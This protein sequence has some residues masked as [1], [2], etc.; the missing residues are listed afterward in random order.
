MRWMIL[1]GLPATLGLIL[2]AE[3][4]MYTLFQ[5]DRFSAHDALMASRSL[6]AYAIGLPGF[7]A[8]KILAPG[9]SARQ[10]LATPAR[11]GVYAVLVNLALS[12]LLVLII[13]PEG[14][15]HA[16]L[17]LAVSLA[18]IYNAALLFGKLA[19]E[20]VYHAM[21][22]ARPFYGRV[23]LAN[24][25]MGAL[26]LRAAA[27]HPWPIWTTTERVLHL[28]LWIALGCAAYVLTLALTGLRPRHLLL[29]NGA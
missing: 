17:A 20:G 23:L 3:P 13:A 11:Y 16:G 25:V 8:V 1:V 6:M 14:W 21:P 27:S 5:H 22:G 24:A 7:L 4:L 12:L 29:P 9:F 10:D 2:L 28:G 19:R 15:E 18:T 26:L